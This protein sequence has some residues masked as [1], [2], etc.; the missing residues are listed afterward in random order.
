MKFNLH[1]KVKL[2]KEIHKEITGNIIAIF[3]GDEGIQYKVR[4]FWECKPIEVYFFE[5]EL[6]KYNE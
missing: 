3:I 4:Y 5:S 6:E 1:E 2:P